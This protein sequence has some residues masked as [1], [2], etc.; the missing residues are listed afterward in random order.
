M[1]PVTLVILSIVLA[2]VAGLVWMVVHLRREIRMLEA[3]DP[4]SSFDML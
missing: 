3:P 4:T 2:L 1:E